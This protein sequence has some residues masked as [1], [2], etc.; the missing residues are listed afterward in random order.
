MITVEIIDQGIVE[1]EEPM[2]LEKLAKRQ[3]S[4]HDTIIVAAK[5]NNKL[6]EL[7]YTIEPNQ[8]IEFID[9][10]HMDGIRIY[11]RGLTFL[12]IRSAKECYENLNLN[13]LHSLSKGLYFETEFNRRL[14]Q[15]DLR[16]IKE[17]MI[18]IVKQDDPFEKIQVSKEEAKELYHKFNMESKK[19][20]LDFR[21]LDY[22][23]LY[24]ND[25]LKDYFYG[26]MV[27]ST[28]YLE[29]FDLML[30]DD[31]IILRHPTNFSPK[32]VPQFIESPQLGKIF[33]EYENWA[34]ILNCSYVANLNEHVIN[35]NYREIINISE[36]LHTKKISKIADIITEQKK[37]VILIS[38]P[39]SSGKTTFSK[40]LKIHLK[41][42]GLNPI[43]LSV[44]DYFVNRENTPLDENGDYDFETIDAVDLE[45]FNIHLNDMLQG[46]KVEIPRFNFQKG[47]REFK[48]DIVELTEDQ[49]IIIEGIHGLNPKLTKDIF[50]KDKFRIYASALTQLNIDIHNRIPTTDARLIRRIVRD[51]QFRGHDAK[52][53][54]SLWNNV[55][56]GEEK[57]IF[58]YQE[59][60]DIMF[61]SALMYELAI[62]KKHVM[63]LLKEITRDDEQYMEAVRLLKFLQYFESIED[64]QLIPNDSILKEFIGGSV[65]NY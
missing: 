42:N 17:R 40:R 34:S 25:W 61:N 18:E 24:K 64:D 8:K 26:Y 59:D 9:L 39:S 46:D 6:K 58:P 15:K 33:K 63:P 65:F 11:Q 29:L 12:L 30:Y 20:L 27:P 43:T 1:V 48:G 36:V 60:A 19:D 41:V 44:D 55:R 31:G 38:G 49:P 21:K 16:K 53:T 50:E 5:V 47:K 52:K 14:T 45:L 37:R 7:T 4:D 13:L 56:K 57:Y 10:S 3:M 2:T 51:N 35:G 32:E 28:G 23:N 62:L 54:I 22:I